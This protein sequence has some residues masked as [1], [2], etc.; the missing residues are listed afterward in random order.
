MDW[1]SSCS[2]IRWSEESR[3]ILTFDMQKKKKIDYCSTSQN[4]NFF[5]NTFHFLLIVAA[6]SDGE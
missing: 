2:P 1:L 4:D 3:W 5:K 6:P